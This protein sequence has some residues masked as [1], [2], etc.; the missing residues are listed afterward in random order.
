MLNRSSFLYWGSFP[1]SSRKIGQI[2]TTPCDILIY[3]IPDIIAP[4]P[5]LAGSISQK[6]N[7]CCCLSDFMMNDNSDT[8]DPEKRAFWD[9]S[10]N[11]KFNA[12]E[13]MRRNRS[14]FLC[15]SPIPRFLFIK[16]STSFF[17][18]KY[19]F[20]KHKKTWISSS[21]TV[22]EMNRSS[23]LKQLPRSMRTGYHFFPWWTVSFLF[24]NLAH[25]RW[26]K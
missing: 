9:L 2:I 18:W 17:Y 16:T 14:F 8:S 26:L 10:L 13:C 19:I 6:F 24:M 22:R 15:W 1:L 21:V 12:V 23:I 3:S 4:P 25:Y 20:V 7:Y 11:Q 5:T